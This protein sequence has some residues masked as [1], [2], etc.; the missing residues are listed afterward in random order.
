MRYAE[1]NFPRLGVPYGYEGLVFVAES[2]V[3]GLV[4]LDDF[5]DFLV[6]DE[7]MVVFVKDPGFKVLV[8]GVSQLSVFHVAKI[9]KI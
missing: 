8:L 4:A 5:P 9:D 7:N 1:E 6:D 3:P 2:L